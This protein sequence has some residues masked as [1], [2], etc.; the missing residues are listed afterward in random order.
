MH[1]SKKPGRSNSAKFFI[2]LGDKERIGLCNIGTTRTVAESE[3][4]FKKGSPEK[5][6]YCVLSGAFVV[7]SRDPDAPG[8]RFEP[9]DL[10]GETGLSSWDAEYHPFSPKSRRPFSV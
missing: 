8:C 10:I 7:E 3:L 2:N 9:G 6:I 4:L 5:T 1:A